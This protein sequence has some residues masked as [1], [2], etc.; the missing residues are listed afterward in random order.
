MIDDN[1]VDGDSVIDPLDGGSGDNLAGA[2]GAAGL[3]IGDERV[4]HLGTELSLEVGRA[5][6]EDSVD[7]GIDTSG[8]E[9]GDGRGEILDEADLV[10]RGIGA[11]IVPTN[12]VGETEAGQGNPADQRDAGGDGRVGDTSDHHETLP[13]RR[14]ATYG[15]AV[16]LAILGLIALRFA[17]S[18]DDA[19]DRQEVLAFSEDF[20]KT[21]TSYDYQTFDETQEAI[22]AVSS[23]GFTLRYS[24]LLGETGF[25]DA[26]TQN[27]STATS[28]IQVG[29]LLATYE[30]NEA[31]AFAI[32]T[33][34]ITGTQFEEPQ[35]TR[36]RVEVLMIR[37][38]DGWVVV[39]VETT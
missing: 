38:S 22:E 32:V 10:G 8:V 14:V 2:A 30:K 31:R 13:R 5:E 29:P 20:I 34:Q 7:I 35:S 33:Q 4:S 37:T 25:L 16:A 3:E 21:F 24:S 39:D 28:E 23:Q 18:D 12:D 9:G 15:A 17:G 1:E 6:R 19:S 36:L 11:R 27:Q 26:L